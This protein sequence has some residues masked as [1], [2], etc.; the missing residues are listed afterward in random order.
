M[1]KARG[2]AALDHYSLLPTYYVCRKHTRGCRLC[3]WVAHLRL[4]RNCLRSLNSSRHGLYS[5]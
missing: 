5:T 2:L 4:L 3:S 1:R